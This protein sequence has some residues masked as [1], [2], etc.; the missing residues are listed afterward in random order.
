MCWPTSNLRSGFCLLGT[1]RFYT[2]YCFAG[3][4]DST[5]AY[6]IEE[7]SVMDSVNGR[8]EN[9]KLALGMDVA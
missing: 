8:A 7:G 4:L 9:A 6:D 1:G 2:R 5:A 3:R